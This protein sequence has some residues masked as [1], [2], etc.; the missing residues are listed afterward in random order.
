MGKGA[1]VTVDN[2][3]NAL[4]KVEVGG[5]NCMNATGTWTNLIPGGQDSAREYIEAQASGIPCCCE[6]S[7]VAYGIAVLDPQTGQFTNS[8][9]FNLYEYSNVWTSSGASP[10]VSVTCVPDGDQYKVTVVYNG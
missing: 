6:H 7:S 4:V 10:N 2:K 1:F 9:S 8:G 3:S 5:T